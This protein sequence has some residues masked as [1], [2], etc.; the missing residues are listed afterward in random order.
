MAVAGEVGGVA[1]EATGGEAMPG[2]A[3]RGAL[4]STSADMVRREL[5]LDKWTVGGGGRLKLRRGQPDRRVNTHTCFPWLL[6]EA[7]KVKRVWQ[8]GQKKK[9]GKDEELKAFVQT[10]N[11]T[12]KKQL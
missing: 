1:A 4:L 9:K 6:S 3:G 2:S 5:H 8:E 11:W 10:K 7:E 12:T